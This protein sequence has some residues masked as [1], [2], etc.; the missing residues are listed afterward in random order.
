MSSTTNQCSQQD[1]CENYDG[2]YHCNCSKGFY[3]ENDNRTCTGT[4]KYS[5]VSRL[6]DTDR[7][8]FRNIIRLLDFNWF[9]KCVFIVLK[10]IEMETIY[11]R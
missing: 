6:F 8:N 5:D 2:G 1:T 9:F 10:A 7:L 4:L 11:P 3:L